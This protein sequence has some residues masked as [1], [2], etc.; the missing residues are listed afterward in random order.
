[1]EKRLAKNWYIF[2]KIQDI[3]FNCLYHVTIPVKTYNVK[4]NNAIRL[5]DKEGLLP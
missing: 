1:M 5:A 2:I 4:Q 3:Y